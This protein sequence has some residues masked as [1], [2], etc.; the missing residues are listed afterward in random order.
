VPELPVQF[1]PITGRPGNAVALQGPAL[2]KQAELLE[3]GN[4]PAHPAVLGSLPT[5]TPT[6]GGDDEK[7]SGGRNK[8]VA[9]LVC[10]LN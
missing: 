10:L 3:S 5:D 9:I 8:T 4:S 6:A 2:A 1:I 7:K